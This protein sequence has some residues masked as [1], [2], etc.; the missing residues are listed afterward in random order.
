MGRTHTW[1]TLQPLSSC[2]KSL[3]CGF[4]IL[5]KAGSHDMYKNKLGINTGGFCFVPVCPILSFHRRWDIFPEHHCVNLSLISPHT[6]TGG[7]MDLT[8]RWRS[9]GC[10]RLRTGALSAPSW[11]PPARRWTVK[12]SVKHWNWLFC[13]RTLN[14]RKTLTITSIKTQLVQMGFF[15]KGCVKSTGQIHSSRWQ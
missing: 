15:L 10:P 3:S 9:T 7:L 11:R 5:G 6:E 13:R 8:W 12:K 2:M 14:E 4:S 1:K